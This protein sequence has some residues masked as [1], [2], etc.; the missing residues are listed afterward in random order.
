VEYIIK[1]DNL[2]FPGTFDW[3]DLFFMGIGT[4]VES[5]LYRNFIRRRI[6]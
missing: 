2:R 5:S 1:T 3:L 6:I 4:F